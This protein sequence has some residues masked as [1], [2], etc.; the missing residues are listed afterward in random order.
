MYHQ[1]DDYW[2]SQYNET[3][4]VR[5]SAWPKQPVEIHDATLRDG[6]QTPGVVFSPDDKLKIAE[7]LVAAGVTRIEAGMPAVSED[8]RKAIK[9]ISHRLPEANLY[10]FVRATRGDIDLAAESGVNGVVIE[11]PIGKPKLLYQFGWTW[12]TV[13]EKSLDS[14]AYA[15]QQGL[16]VTFFPYDTTRA[17]PEDL[18]GLLT[19]VAQNARPDAV[20]LVDTMGCALP[21]TIAYMVR[22]IKKLTDDLPVEVHCHNDFG[23]ATACELAGAAAGASVLHACVNGIGERTGNAATEEL[24]FAMTLLFQMD[25]PYRWD[26]MRE[27]CA[28]VAQLSGIPIAQNKPFS[29]DRN[30]MRESGIGSNLVIEKPLAMFAVNPAFIGAT[31]FMVLGKKSGKTSVEFCLD[32]I[33]VQATGEQVDAILE[34]VKALGT[35]KKRL[36]TD[37]EFAAIVKDI[38]K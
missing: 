13:L 25:T 2:V 17:D 30:F 8:D 32:K 15:R 22:W 37:D 21:P 27:L 38:V 26:K 11:A 3:P 6:E 20:G 23:M 24:A 33:G 7:Q 5:Q 18:E 31:P 16:K 36:V 34:R 14:I 1:N 28:T 19:G 10:A 35:Q 9:A 4:E 29:G 12:Q